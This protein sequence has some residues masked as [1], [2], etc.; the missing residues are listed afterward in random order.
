MSIYIPKIPTY[1]Q[2][3]EAL[4]EAAKGVVTGYCL[5]GGSITVGAAFGLTRLISS[6]CQE[7]FKAL[8]QLISQQTGAKLRTALT[9]GIFYALNMGL[10]AFALQAAGLKKTKLSLP[11]AAVVLTTVALSAFAKFKIDEMQEKEAV[12]NENLANL[13]NGVL[14][15]AKGLIA[16][17]LLGSN[18]LLLPLAFAVNNVYFARKESPADDDYQSYP[19]IQRDQHLEKCLYDVGTYA[20]LNAASMALTKAPWLLNKAWTAIVDFRNKNTQIIQNAEAGKGLTASEGSRL[21]IER[22]A[23]KVVVGAALAG[24]AFW[25]K[26]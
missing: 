16:A 17:Q 2:R 25:L 1:E 6:S 4:G 24:L 13:D 12:V 9:P 21:V 15:A 23:L 7:H 22:L 18:R 8:N 3:I 19:E 10:T 20:V 14:G 5:G 11:G 26:K